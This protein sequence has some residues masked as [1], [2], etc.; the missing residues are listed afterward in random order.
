MS[1]E[2]VLDPQPS[3]VKLFSHFGLIPWEQLLLVVLC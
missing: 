2:Y 3:V 1:V